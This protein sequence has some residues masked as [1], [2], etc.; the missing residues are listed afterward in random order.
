MKAF[1][2]TRSVIPHSAVIGCLMVRLRMHFSRSFHVYT[3]ANEYTSEWQDTKRPDAQGFNLFVM[4]VITSDEQEASFYRYDSGW[5]VIRENHNGL[6]EAKTGNIAGET[7]GGKLYTCCINMKRVKR[8]KLAL[9]QW[10]SSQFSLVFSL[11]LFLHSLFSLI[12]SHLPLF[13][14]PS[15]SDKCLFVFWTEN[16]RV[17]CTCQKTADFFLS[18]PVQFSR[19]LSLSAQTSAVQE[20]KIQ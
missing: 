10:Q 20:K 18:L 5:V 2:W 19:N 15:C 7:N 8:E 4:A 9:P 12:H 1:L 11:Y 3:R 13:F 6:Y 16:C 14:L 17:Q